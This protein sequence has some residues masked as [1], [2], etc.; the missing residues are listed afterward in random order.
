M[1]SLMFMV[2]LLGIGWLLRSLN[3]PIDFAKSLNFFI[4]HISLPATIFLQIP[5]IEFS[6]NSLNVILAP[7]LLLLITATLVWWLTRGQPSGVRAA[8]MLLV[9]LGNTSFLGIPMIE[10]LVGPSVLGYVVLDDQFGT[11][12]ILATYGSFIIAHQQHGHLNWKIVF[13][14]LV[15]F[16]PFLALIFI[17]LWGKMPDLTL[18][19]LKQLSSTLIPL[20]LISVGYTI[21][22][23][24][25][26]K[27]SLL[28]FGLVMKLLVT[29]IIAIGIL[30][31]FNVDPMIKETIVL[32]AA[33]PSMI[34]A[35]AL[36][37]SAGFA[38]A[39]SA[40]IVGY[41]VILSMVSV[42]FWHWIITRL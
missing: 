12:L 20:A 19:Y 6:V 9:P 40:A 32:E 14:K 24:K 23:S 28:S 21:E 41:G 11:F 29:P 31:F 42:P 17:L 34:T 27:Y 18:P 26:L 39:L 10:A 8:L 33:M 3:A 38:P 37:I 5:A 25:S 22:V 7:W 36:A 16:P 30:A 35:G 1:E 15:T 4:I 2:V 13:K